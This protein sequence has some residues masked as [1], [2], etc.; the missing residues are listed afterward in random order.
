M[1]LDQPKGWI[2]LILGLILVVLGVLPLLARF[3]ILG[4]NPIQFIT[5]ILGMNIAQYIVAIAGLVLIINAFMEADTLRIVSLIVG[6]IILAAG[7]IPVLN[8]AGV[9]PFNIPFLSDLV[10]QILFIVEGIFL[11]I[12]AFAMW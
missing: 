7:V 4:A 8:G 6:V 1:A 9:I 5:N 10:Y 11:V 2:S 3:K 12:A